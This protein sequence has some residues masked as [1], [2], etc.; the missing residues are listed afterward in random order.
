MADEY[1]DA[2]TE[3][4]NDK[5][6]TDS[7]NTKLSPEDEAKFQGWA[8]QN[9]KLKDAYDYD[10]RGFWKNDGQLDER[11]HGSDLY[12]KPNH[13]TFSDQS[14][15]HGQ[16]GQYGGQWNADE[17]GN[18]VSFT[19]SQTNLKNMSAEQLGQYFK[20]VEP[21]IALDLPTAK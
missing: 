9:G 11:A 6:L 21:N 4:E 18:T 17:S 1:A 12:K 3:D 13:P 5:G 15:Y 19:P 7:Y 14:M 16:D 8:T 10:I 2:W 20:E